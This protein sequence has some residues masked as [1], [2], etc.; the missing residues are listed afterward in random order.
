M[1]CHEYD[2][3]G[4]DTGKQPVMA[5]QCNCGTT[6]CVEQIKTRIQE[7]TEIHPIDR[8][9]KSCGVPKLYQNKNCHSH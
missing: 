1:N 3:G 2:T 6:S 4:R 7:I 9:C 8:P 5:W